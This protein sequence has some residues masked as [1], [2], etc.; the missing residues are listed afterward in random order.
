MV[1]LRDQEEVLA[2]LVEALVQGYHSGF[3]KSIQNYSQILQLFGEAKDQV[4]LRGLILRM[5]HD[6]WGGGREEG[7]LG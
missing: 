7:D 5:V 6:Y 3:A 2:E 1:Q 4:G